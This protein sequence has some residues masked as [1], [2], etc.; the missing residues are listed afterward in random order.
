MTITSPGLYKGAA[1]CAAVGGA[2]YCGVQIEHPSATVAHLLTTNVEVREALKSVFCML[3]IVGITGM[4]LWQRARLGLL[5][6][7]GY[8]LLTIGFFAIFAEQAIVGIA[9]PTVAVKDPQ[10]VQHVLNAAVG[11]GPSDGIGHVKILLALCG[12]GYAGGGLLFGIAMFRTR[13]IA[14]WAAALLAVGAIAT[15]FLAFLPES[16]NRPFAVPVGIALIGLGVSL[17]RQQ[18]RVISLVDPVAAPVEPAVVG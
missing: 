8:V 2:I 13:M 7:V 3:A 1:A 17:W 5:G 9:L 4:F 6:L 10:Y 15:P 16:Y 14:Q 18:P 11:H 12:A